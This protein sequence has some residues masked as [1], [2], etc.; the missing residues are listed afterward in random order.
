[1]GTLI[2]ELEKSAASLS[3]FD[4]LPT[5]QAMLGPDEDVSVKLLRLDDDLATLHATLLELSDRGSFVYNSPEFVGSGFLP[6]ATDQ[7]GNKVIIGQT[8]PLNSISLVDM[9]P[10]GDHM[11]RSIVETFALKD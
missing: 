1:L 7:K 5:E 3:P 4:V 6:H 10:G 2:R 8:Y 9:F 11:Q